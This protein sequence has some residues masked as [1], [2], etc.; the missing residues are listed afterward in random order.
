MDVIYDE[1]S[2]DISQTNP[3]KTDLNTNSLG[4][5][6][7]NFIDGAVGFLTGIVN[8]AT[9]LTTSNVYGG[10]VVGEITGVAEVNASTKPVVNIF[11]YD[12]ASV[13]P[14]ISRGLFR[15][16][17]G[18]RVLESINSWEFD[19]LALTNDELSEV[20]KFPMKFLSIAVSRS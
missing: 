19:A 4:S 1:A 6:T 2:E 20:C 10:V 18:K 7:L 9:D 5:V 13:A 14:W 8:A 17:M 3:M 11:G 12:I 16:P 15:R